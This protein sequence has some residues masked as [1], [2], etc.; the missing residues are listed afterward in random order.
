MIRTP[1]GSEIELTGQTQVFTETTEPGIYTLISEGQEISFAVNLADPESET[2][3]LGIERLKQFDIATG[4]VPTQAEELQKMRQLRD[5][6]LEQ[7]QKIWKWMIVAVLVLL[8]VETLLAAQRT[9]QPS[10]EAGDL[11]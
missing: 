6:E 9:S 11:A 1:E 2:Q 10:Q 7:R 5:A 4:T 3:P 8:G